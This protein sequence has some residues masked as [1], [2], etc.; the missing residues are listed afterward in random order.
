MSSTSEEL[1]LIHLYHHKER[2]RRQLGWLVQQSHLLSQQYYMWQIRHE[3][4]CEKKSPVFRYTLHLRLITVK[5]FMTAMAEKMQQKAAE[6]MDLSA[7]ID[8]LGI[9]EE[10]DLE[11]A[12][13]EQE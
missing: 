7:L 13:E 9:M 12:S 3:R 6:L 5:G 11:N 1:N 2:C 10:S 4:A 8:T